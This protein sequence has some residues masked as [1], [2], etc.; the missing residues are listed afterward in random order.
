MLTRRMQYQAIADALAGIEHVQPNL[1][2]FDSHLLA[3][4]EAA[5]LLPPNAKP[6]MIKSVFIGA[7]KQRRDA[8]IIVQNIMATKP[9]GNGGGGLSFPSL[10]DIACDL[11]PIKW[12]WPGWIACGMLSLLGATKGAGKTYLCLDLSNRVIKNGTFPDGQPVGI[13][14]AKVLYI[15]AEFIP[16]VINERVTTLEMD[17]SRFYVPVVDIRHP[18]D[19][20]TQRDRDMLVEMMNTIKP[21]MIVLD[22]LGNLHSKGENAVEDVRDLMQFLVSV[23]YEFQCAMILIHHL[24]KRNPLAFMDLISLDDFRGSGHIVNMARTIM[25]L[26]IIQNTSSHNPNGPRRFEVISTNL[27]RYPEPLGVEFK[28]LYPTGVLLDYGEPPQAYREPSQDDKA[29]QWLLDIL[30]DGPAKPDELVERAKAYIGVS[31]A[32]LFRAHDKLEAAGMIKNTLG[33][34]NPGNEWQLSTWTPK[35]IQPE[36]DAK[37]VQAKTQKPKQKSK[38]RQSAKS[39]KPKQKSKLHPKKG[40]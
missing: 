8:E 26:S 33:T 9:C 32:T 20:S 34:K 39:Q 23:A 7:I 31:R 5:K 1:A 6:D 14:D 21:N 13:P 10:G 30:A 36:S 11:K 38:P 18:I 37:L 24:R 29:R 22:S 40:K 28:S 2:Q 27:A 12:F 25:G 16:Q 19:M 15:D 3:L 17:K 4:Y 35:P